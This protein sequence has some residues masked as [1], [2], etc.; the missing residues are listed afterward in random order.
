MT[1]LLWD[2][3]YG[4]LGGIAA[5]FIPIHS[6]RDVPAEL[7]PV[8]LKSPFFWVVTGFRILLGGAVVGLYV[9]SGSSLNPMLCFHV[10]ASLPLFIKNVLSNAPRI[11]PGPSD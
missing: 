2:A 9:K 7:R 8:W 5:E 11:E 4:V 3:L 10:G 1:D 6:I